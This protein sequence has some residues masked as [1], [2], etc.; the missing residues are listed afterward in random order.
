[1][2]RQH[3]RPE[4]RNCFS[5]NQSQRKRSTGKGSR[6]DWN[7][8]RSHWASDNRRRW[9]KGKMY[10]LCCSWLVFAIPSRCFLLVKK[11]VFFCQFRAIQPSH[12]FGICRLSQ[13]RSFRLRIVW[14][15]SRSLTSFVVP[16]EKRNECCACLYLVPAA[17][18][19]AKAL[20]IT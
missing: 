6:K 1:M 7:Q 10:F 11:S 19:Q 2:F 18:D 20:S 8:G 14:L 13:C 5:R 17:T 12:N 9:K 15:I 4:I 16:L 3:T